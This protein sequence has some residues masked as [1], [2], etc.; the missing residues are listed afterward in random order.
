MPARKI[1]SKGR[2]ALGAK[3]ANKDVI[4]EKVNEGFLIRPA[5][6]IPE[7]E[8]WLY[9]NK[10]VLESVLKGISQA[11]RKEFAPNPRKKNRKWLEEVED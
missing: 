2:I 10:E 5:V 8:V 9:K 3:Y 11:K 4:V 7:N 6:L 1:D